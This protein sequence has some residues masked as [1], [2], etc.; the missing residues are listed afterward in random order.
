MRRF[1]LPAVRPRGAEIRTARAGV[2]RA[3]RAALPAVLGLLAGASAMAQGAGPDPD[4]PNA[5]FVR[6]SN[7][8]VTAVLYTPDPDKGYYRATRFDW[9]G[10]IA[11]LT[12]GGHSYFGRWFA[13]YDP[14]VHDA[15]MGPVQEYVTGQGYE[16]AKPGGTF[17]KVGVG[18]LRKPMTPITRG[19]PTLEIVD[20]GK[21]TTVVHKDSVEFDQVVQDP[22]SGYGYRY[23]KIVSLPAGKSELVL[24]QRIESIG[25][26]PIDTDT[27]NHNFFMLDGQPSGPDV[28]LRFPW[29]VQA[30]KDTGGMVVVDG[31]S[32]T[33]GKLL[34]AA[35]RPH[36][37]LT[38]FGPTAADYEI[39]VENRKTG[40]GVKVTADRPLATLDFWSSPTVVC[41]EAYIHVHADQGH[42]MSWKVTYDFYAT[43]TRASASENRVVE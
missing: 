13:K 38:G 10:Q 14:K 28:Q 31:Q 2:R 17:V 35:D 16:A 33:Y 19:F 20:S 43:P 6:I 21:W 26:N 40:A 29:K 42:P 12:V 37:K 34:A 7:G 9:S 22:A 30:E 36:T 5:P 32:V 11:S 25:P 15:I 27:Y 18:V 24:D 8:L 4:A 41:P 23:R 1:D 3:V 39:R